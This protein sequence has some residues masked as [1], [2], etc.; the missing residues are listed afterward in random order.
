MTRVVGDETQTVLGRAGRRLTL[1]AMTSGDGLTAFEA[2][3]SPRTRCDAQV[4]TRRAALPTRE[5]GSG[6]RM[7]LYGDGG[8]A[9]HRGTTDG[10][11]FARSP[12]Q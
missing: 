9:T 5:V 11:Y 4:L 1:N 10:D 12:I 2:P 8:V 6:S 3:E 7:C